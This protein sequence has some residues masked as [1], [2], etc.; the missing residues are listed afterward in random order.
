[1]GFISPF[2]HPT[3]LKIALYHLRSISMVCDEP[4]IEPQKNVQ[5]YL[6]I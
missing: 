1:M 2:P 3:F 4:G 5:K 6:N